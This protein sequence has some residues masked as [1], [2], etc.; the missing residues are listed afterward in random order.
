MN[1]RLTVTTTVFGD[2]DTAALTKFEQHYDTTTL[3]NG[4]DVLDRLRVRLHDP[5]GLRDDLLA[6][7]GMA[8]TI[9]NGASI[10]TSGREGTFVEQVLD[11]LDLIDDYLIELQR[12]RTVLEPL[13]ALYPDDEQDDDQ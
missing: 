8:H 2:V 10:V 13:E 9:L 4:V 6:I 3:L 12:I 1:A 7:H 5:E 11:A